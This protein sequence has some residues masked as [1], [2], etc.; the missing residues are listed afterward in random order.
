MKEISL[1]IIT[2]SKVIYS[3]NVKSIT[4]PGTKGSFQVLYNHAPIISTFEIGRIK[5]VDTDDRELNFATSGGT[6]EVSNNKIL[7]LA[8][9]AELPEN[10]DLERAK[11]SLD[12]AQKRLLTKKDIDIQRAEGAM[13][14]AKNRINIFTKYRTN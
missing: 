3:G 6:V 12:R 4:V 11:E 13:A 8:E 2:P 9:T 5:I 14:R 10:I 7:V 1:E